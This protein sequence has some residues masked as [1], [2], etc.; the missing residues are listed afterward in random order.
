MRRAG[1]FSGMEWLLPFDIYDHQSLPSAP[2]FS[3]DPLRTFARAWFHEPL[4]CALSREK[5]GPQTRGSRTK[6]REIKAVGLEL[7]RS[8]GLGAERYRL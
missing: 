3:C 4:G 7:F 6:S 1:S 8:S 2:L 5:V